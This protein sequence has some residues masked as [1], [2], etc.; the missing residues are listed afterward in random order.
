MN[1]P[2]CHSVTSEGSFLE[3]AVM[4]ATAPKSRF[5]IVWIYIAVASAFGKKAMSTD[6]F[7]CFKIE[8]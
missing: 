6:I 3:S 4:L 8:I 5:V 7:G 1:E 2:K